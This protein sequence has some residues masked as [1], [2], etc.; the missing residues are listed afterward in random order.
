MLIEADWCWLMLIDAQIRFKWVFFCRSVPPELLRSFFDLIWLFWCRPLLMS[1]GWQRSEFS[2]WVA[3]Q[4]SS[5]NTADHSIGLQS[6]WAGTK[7]QNNTT[8]QS[9]DGHQGIAGHYR[10]FKIFKT[11]VKAYL[12]TTTISASNVLCEVQQHMHVGYCARGN[13]VMVLWWKQ[14]GTC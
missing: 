5:P 14:S 8:N 1:W 12:C 11:D 3:E 7:K 4:R 13:T 2:K 10:E 6:R 9:R